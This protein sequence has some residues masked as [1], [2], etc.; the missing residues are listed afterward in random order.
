MFQQVWS[1]SKDLLSEEDEF[2]SEWS[3]EFL[4]SKLRPTLLKADAENQ[5]STLREEE[6]YQ[7]LNK[8]SNHQSALMESAKVRIIR[9]FQPLLST[10]ERANKS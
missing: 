10:N 2:S 9:L 6:A 5:Q 7:A 3:S 1:T 8:F 4:T